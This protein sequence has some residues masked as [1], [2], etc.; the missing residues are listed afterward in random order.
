MTVA[1]VGA[2]LS[3]LA[4]ARILARAG[5]KVTVFEARDR[6]GGRVRTQALAGHRF[7]AGAEWVDSDHHRVIRLAEEAGAGLVPQLGRVDWFVTRDG[8]SEGTPPGTD[9]AKLREYCRAHS[10]GTLLDAIRAVAPSPL[11]AFAMAARVRSDEGLDAEDI[12]TEGFLAGQGVYDGREAGEMSAFRLGAGSSS[13]CD[14]LAEGLS[15]VRLQTHVSSLTYNLRKINLTISSGL[16]TFDHCIVAVPPE[17][18][19]RLAASVGMA[20]SRPRVAPVVKAALRFRDPFWEGH[21]WNGSML[22]DGPAQQTWFTQDGGLLMA[23]VCGREAV[24]LS[25]TSSAIEE[26]VRGLDALWPGAAAAFAEGTFVNWASDPW[27]M[28][29][30]SARRSDPSQDPEGRLAFAG[31]QFSEWYGFLE[32][33]LESAER[34]TD[35]VIHAAN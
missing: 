13:L 23:Y 20:L 17:H 32:G 3:G 8:R 15:D 14:H 1:V 30:F 22:S 10:G 18:A 24:R 19:V 12:S 26:I 5:A 11:S 7:E 28:C 31:E 27:S 34:A 25:G 16:E 33:A 2:G 21:G 9:E 35:E 6:I 4:A 29:G